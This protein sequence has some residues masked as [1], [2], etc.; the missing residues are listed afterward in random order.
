MGDQFG[1]RTTLLF[2]G[3]ATLLL[4]VAAWRQ[5]VIRRLRQLPDVDY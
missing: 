5:P 1:L 2:S 3:V 4:A